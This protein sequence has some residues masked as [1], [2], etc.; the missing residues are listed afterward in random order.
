MTDFLLFEIS[1]IEYRLHLNKVGV[2][3]LQ[4]HRYENGASQPT[5]EVIN[6]IA[7]ALS[8]TTSTGGGRKLRPP[9]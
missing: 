4:I 6:R 8:V 7:I 5:L 3:V 9:Q 2:K 1:Y